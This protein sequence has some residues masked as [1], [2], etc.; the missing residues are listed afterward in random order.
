MSQQYKLI[1]GEKIPTPKLVQRIA[2]DMKEY[3]QPGYVVKIIEI[4]N[5][6]YYSIFRIV[7]SLI[8]KFLLALRFSIHWSFLQI[9]VR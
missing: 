3:N 7:H 6:R 4:I 8:T 9:I 5:M 1:Y 2:I